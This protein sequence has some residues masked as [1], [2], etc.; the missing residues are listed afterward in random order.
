MLADLFR[1][2]PEGASVRVWVAAR[3][4]GE[5]ANSMAI[6]LHERLEQLNLRYQA[7]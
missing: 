1:A 2:Y 7:T 3:S 5:E 6:L 4:T